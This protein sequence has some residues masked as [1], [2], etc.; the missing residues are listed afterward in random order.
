[1][2]TLVRRSDTA[3]L[4]RR[5]LF[6]DA[7]ASAATALILALGAQYLTGL[8]G[9]PL[10]LMR[11]AGISLLPFAA[12]LLFVGMRNAPPRIPVIAIIACNALWAFGSVVLLASGFVNP[13][14]LGTAFV[15]AQA[16]AVG[17]FAGLQWIGLTRLA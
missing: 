1:M 5:A 14:L 16:V 13:T 9:L 11:F 8:F 12:I 17:M 3:S 10:R 7:A 4:L 6:A 15:I 2:T